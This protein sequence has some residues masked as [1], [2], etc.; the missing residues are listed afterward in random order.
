MTSPNRDDIRNWLIQ[1]IAEETGKETTSVSTSANFV[2]LG[3]TSYQAIV[4]IANLE[5]HLN[6]SVPL[7]AGLAWSL[8]T[9][10]DLSMH[11]AEP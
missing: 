6:P 3:L 1:Y 4:M 8:P 9:I 10:D 7:D 2:N 11:L 5:K